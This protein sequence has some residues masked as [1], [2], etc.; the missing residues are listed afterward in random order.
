MKDADRADAGT[1]VEALR[2]M[3]WLVVP[4]LALL[5]VLTLLQYNQRIED[6]ERGLLRRAEEHAQV[7]ESMARPA[8]AHVH[9]LRRLLEL[10]WSAPPHSGE[11]IRNAL[12][13]LPASPDSPPEVRGIYDGW[14]LDEASPEL[15]RA[16][17]QVWWAPS[18]GSPPNPAWM[19]RAAL[20]MRAARVA[21]ERAPGFQGSYFVAAETHVTWGFPWIDT[22]TM[23]ASMGVPSLQ[24]LERMRLAGVDRGRS[25]LANNPEDLTY[26]GP[27]YIGQLDGE[28]VQS[29][30]SMIL[31]QGQ[32]AGEVSV[33]FRIESLQRLA[34]QWQDREGARVWVVDRER[35]VVADSAEPLQVPKRRGLANQRV[36]I[37]LESRLPEGLSQKVSSVMP[38]TAN[39]LLAHQGAWVLLAAA[40]ADSPW[41]YVHAVP[42]ASLR[43][44]ILPSL[45]P[46]GVLGLALLIVFLAGQW[47]FARWFVTP[48]LS[49][50][51]YLRQL[52]ADPATPRPF[53]GRRWEGW[54]RAINQVFER[55]RQAQQ[56]LE[57]QRETLRQNEK[58][59]AMG[60]LLAGV[61]HELNNPLAIVMGR[62]SLLEERVQAGD[63]ERPAA[64]LQIKDDSRRIREAADRCGRIVR[65]F[66]NMARQRPATRSAVQVGDV[67]R[68]TLEMVGYTLRSR[69]IQVE[70][71]LAPDLPDVQA[72]ADQ[73]GQVVLNLVVN[74]QQALEAMPGPRLL[75]IRTG[76]DTEPIK[77]WVD[78]TV[79]HVWLQVS[80][81]GPG[82]PEDQRENLFEPFFTTK[83]PGLGTGLGLSVSRGIAREHGGDLILERVAGGASFRLMLP[84]AAQHA[85]AP[86]VSPLQS[87]DT[88]SRAQQ[89]LVVDDE[90]DLVE[91]IRASLEL[92]GFDV[93][94]AETGAVALELLSEARFD[95]IVSDMRMPDIDGRALW[96]AVQQRQPDLAR[97]MLFV[98]GDTLST[99]A[100]AT[101][102][103][104]GCASLDKPFE[105]TE[106]VAA[107]RALLKR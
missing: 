63:A 70:L 29:H 94:S 5:V 16:V 81:N 100:R 62:A 36:E 73:L 67:A 56:Q 34:A 106:L 12:R 17:G 4:V 58:L 99:D 3:W 1:R 88:D 26:W 18:D 48:A 35:H 97:R 89:I 102:S 11:F 65:T 72:D 46:N 93:I 83:A 44:E 25:L 90:P 61:A 79:P 42:K 96:K 30:G 19:D 86:A 66:L 87:A 105:R 71:A 68:S 95:A 84:V 57:L 54:V 37:K 28:L 20:F 76:Y 33:D 49:V 47:L 92:A 80:D 64:L 32:Y 2:L 78:G 8:A 82:V 52:S 31:I 24:A 40:R 107:V 104:T 74:A 75:S 91:V 38:A 77:T 101:F 23:L 98:T 27:P 51:Q 45:L 43:A 69:S 15:R 9:D 7:L 41:V 6:A 85:P 10:S 103:E 50:L 13:P 14:T 59:S 53:L 22:P 55:Q 39:G 21:H 60:T